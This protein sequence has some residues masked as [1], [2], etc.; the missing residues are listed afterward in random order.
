LTKISCERRDC[1]HCVDGECS[2]GKIEIKERTVPPDEEIAV[3][4]TFEIVAG[5]C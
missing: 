3:C 5:V 4:N 1:K 2:R